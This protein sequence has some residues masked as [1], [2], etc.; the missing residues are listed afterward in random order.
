MAQ[1]KTSIDLDVAFQEYSRLP[2][3]FDSLLMATVSENG[4]PNSS[5]AAYIKAMGN[6][7]VFVSDLAAHTSNLRLHKQASIMFI[8]NEQDAQHL[9]ARQRVTLLCEASIVDRNGEIFPYIMQLFS[10]KF[11]KFIDLLQEKKDFHLF[12]LQPKSGGYVAGF[13]RAFAIEGKELSEISHVNDMGHKSA[14]SSA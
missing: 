6:Y 13:G 10:Q 14:E 2:E 5:Y 7:Y 9:F 1:K 8:E 12:C 11:G 4:I 3:Q